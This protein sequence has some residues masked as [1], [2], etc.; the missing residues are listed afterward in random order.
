MIVDSATP[1]HLMP[2]SKAQRN[3]GTGPRPAHKTKQEETLVYPFLS[4]TFQLRQLDNG[5]SNGTGLWLGA[6]C[7]SLYLADVNSTLTKAANHRIKHS[8]SKDRRPRAIELGSGVGLGA[9][10]SFSESQRRLMLIRD[11]LTDWLW[12]RQD[13]MSWLRTRHISQ[14]RFCDP[15]SQPIQASSRL[16]TCRVGSWIGPWSLGIGRGHTRTMSRVSLQ[17]TLSEPPNQSWSKS[18]RAVNRQSFLAL[19]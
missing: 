13:G 9:L 15:T 2:P 19:D 16:K 12:R 4:S 3:L 1:T 8:D 14:A 17:T 5:Q 10:D 7:L 18:Q 6:Q 11:P